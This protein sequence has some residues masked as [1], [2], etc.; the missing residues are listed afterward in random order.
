MDFRNTVVIMTSN[1]G[2]SHIAEMHGEE[3]SKIHD[4][5]NEALKASFRPEFLNRID[6]I[7]VFDSLTRDQIKQ[8]VEIQIRNLGDLLAQRGLTLKLSDAALEII[9]SEGFDPVYGAR[10]LRRTIQK[11]I[12]DPLALEV[13]SGNFGENDT[14][15]VDASNGEIVFNTED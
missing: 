14:I 3:R 7:I 15:S 10:P 13:L 8:I 1:V 4:L 11:K 9:A 12:Q 5:I 6:D 2:S